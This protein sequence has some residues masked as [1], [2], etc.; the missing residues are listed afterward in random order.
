VLQQEWPTVLALTAGLIAF[1]SIITTLLGPLFGLSRSDSVRT[2]LL[3][4]G[5]GEFAFVVLTLADK[6][7]VLPDLL[8]KILVGVVIS[9]AL[10]PTLSSI[11]DKIAG[12]ID[13]QE[14]KNSLDVALQSGESSA[15]TAVQQH[16][17]VQFRHLIG[18]R[19]PRLSAHLT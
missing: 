1:K 6:L 4:A 14:R 18:S 7:D 10:T 2:G 16:S 8:A 3:L 17:A 19:S 5:G 15:R 11:A 13:Q 12:Y 9:M